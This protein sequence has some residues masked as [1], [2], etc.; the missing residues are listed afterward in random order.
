ME[1]TQIDREIVSRLGAAQAIL[2]V[3]CGDGRLSCYLAQET[4]CEVI[5]VDLS[6]TGFRKAKK[7]ANETGVE[8]LVRCIKGNATHLHLPNGQVD[9]AILSYSLHHID[10]P[11]ATLREVH[12]V[13]RPGGTIIVSEHE[14]KEKGAKSECFRFTITELMEIL[15][16][17]GFGDIHWWRV[18]AEMLLVAAK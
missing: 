16:E 7:L 1:L 11:S 18:E 3:G 5:G 8:H 10:D 6:P 13:L 9:A 14:L 4:G 12:R 17:A 15:L 2:D